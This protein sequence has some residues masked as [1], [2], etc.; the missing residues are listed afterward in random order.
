MKKI[1]SINKLSIN[2]DKIVNL[3]Q[4]SIVG[5]QIHTINEIAVGS[6]DD[7]DTNGSAY[8][9]AGFVGCIDDMLVVDNRGDEL[10]NTDIFGP[11][12]LNDSPL[13][14]DVLLPGGV[15]VF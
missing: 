3:T 7:C 9:Q 11:A 5:G 2:K 6:W 10:P 12:V 1:K 8:C 15:D 14:V 13:N 4:D